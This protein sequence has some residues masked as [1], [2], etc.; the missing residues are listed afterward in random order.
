[1]ILGG[2]WGAAYSREAQ[3]LH[4][5]VHR[6]RQKIGPDAGIAIKSAPGIGYLLTTTVAEEP[7]G[8]PGTG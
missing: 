5:Y 1:M 3:Y 7:Q 8:S 4:A 2:V 6:L